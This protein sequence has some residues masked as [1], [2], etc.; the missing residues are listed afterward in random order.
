MTKIEWNENFSIGISELDE[1]HKF[2]INIINELLDSMRLKQSKE[3]FPAIFLK[4]NEYIEMHHA[5]EELY[6]KNSNYP[7]LDEHHQEH[8][9]FYESVQNLQKLHDTNLL[10]AK[11]LLNTLCDWV[12]NHIC[13]SDKEFSSFYHQARN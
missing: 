4:L 11:N 5:H 3:A 8:I 1:E 12:I 7:N 2:L 13:S 6:M 10:F 9:K